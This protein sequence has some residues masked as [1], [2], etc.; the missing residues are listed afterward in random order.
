M[1]KQDEETRLYEIHQEKLREL[2]T[3]TNVFAALDEDQSGDLTDEEFQHACNTHPEIRNKFRLLGF[4]DE[5]VLT[6]FED[7]DNGDGLLA[8]SEFLEGVGLLKGQARGMDVVRTMKNVE[9]LHKRMD[10]LFDIVDPAG[11]LTA[12]ALSRRKE[13]GHMVN[14]APGLKRVQS[15]A[16]L[17]EQEL[18]PT[19]P[20]S[21]LQHAQ[22]PT[23]AA[24]VPSPQASSVNGGDKS[25]FVTANEMK[26]LLQAHL[27]EMKI[28]M[29]DVCRTELSQH[30]QKQ[31]DRQVSHPHTLL[32][33]PAVG[34][35][36]PEAVNGQSMHSSPS[37]RHTLLG[38]GCAETPTSVPRHH[39]PGIYEAGQW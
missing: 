25:D 31:S 24:K 29:V 10:L 38:C 22:A 9:R 35:A 20:Q 16:K 12:A 18:H 1:S 37:K 19:V 26:T 11:N 30:M 34:I 14:H 17:A 39:V 32:P 4:D 7:L 23:E 8:I 27:Q 36:V 33:A 6:I 13:R 15:H 3:L 21:V 2:E 5:E 28:L